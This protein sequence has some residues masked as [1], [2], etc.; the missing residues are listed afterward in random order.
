[1]IRIISG[2]LKGRRLAVPKGARPTTDRVRE[3][4][5]SMLGPL[6]S[7]ARV[8]DLYAGS[9]ALGIEA[10][11]RG[12]NVLVAVESSPTSQKVLEA[13]LDFAR[14][15]DGVSAQA[16]RGQ[17]AGR[18][19]RLAGPFDLV[20]ADPPYGSGELELLH[21]RVHP[22]LCAGGVLVVEFS[23]EDGPPPPPGSGWQRITT[24]TY[25]ASG[26]LL[27]EKRQPSHQSGED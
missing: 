17:V 26:I 20:F 25:A 27:D 7:D 19:E 24:R 1:M 13:N 15:I 22:L 11:S 10:V 8:L 4:V 9:G 23:A 5:F 12:A 2:R 14:G 18:I 21:E 6:G 16:I 3:A